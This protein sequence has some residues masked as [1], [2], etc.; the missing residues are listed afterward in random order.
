M[1]AFW[2]CKRCGGPTEKIGEALK[3]AT[4]TFQCQRGG[5]KHLF[6]K[7]NIRKTYVG[8]GGTDRILRDFSP[9]I[10]RVEQ[11]QTEMERVFG[12]DNAQALLRHRRALVE[13]IFKKEGIRDWASLRAL[14][15][16]VQQDSGRTS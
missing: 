5:C 16:D 15:R 2:R 10:R 7:P 14:L 6:V 1:S 11:V 8:G 3:G 13:E 12:Y 4:A 9:A